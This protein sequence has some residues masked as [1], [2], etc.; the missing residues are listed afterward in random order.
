MAESVLRF[1]GFGSV[2]SAAATA[3]TVLIMNR[4][5]RQRIIIQ[6][7]SPYVWQRPR[8]RDF[9]ERIVNEDFTDEMWIQHF[10]MTLDT[11]IELCNVL[12]HLVA[13]DVSCPREAVPTRKRV[14]IALYKLATCSEYRVIGETFGVSKTTVHRCVY[15]VC[16]AICIKLM[17][18]KISLLDVDEALE[19]AQR[20]YESH[21]IPQVYGTIDGSHLVV[22]Q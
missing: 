9:W 12:E 16:Q 20:N 13:P 17:K 11:F 1:H 21:K 19:I 4:R 5:Q 18:R 15:G 10:P 7:Q 14:A 3:I 22:P 8:I 6:R 2:I